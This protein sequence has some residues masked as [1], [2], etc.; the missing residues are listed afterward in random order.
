MYQRFGTSGLETS[1]IQ[2]KYFTGDFYCTILTQ[3][4]RRRESTEIALVG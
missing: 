4:E 2:Q 1:G 3:F